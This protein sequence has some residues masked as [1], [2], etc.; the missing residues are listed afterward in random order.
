MNKS[1]HMVTVALSNDELFFKNYTSFEAKAVIKMSVLLFLCVLTNCFNGILIYCYFRYPI[2]MENSRYVLFIHMV[3][4]DSFE[5][6]IGLTMHIWLEATPL[7]L[8]PV[9]YTL[10]VIAVS[11]TLNNPINLALMALERYIAICKPLHHPKFCTFYRCIAILGLAWVISAIPAITD[12]IIVFCVEPLSF[13]RTS[14]YC[15]RG[16]LFRAP[17]QEQ[18]RLITQVILFTSVT[19][20]IILTYI[21]IVSAARSASLSKKSSAKKAYN[22]VLLHGIQLML[23]MLAFLAPLTDNLIWSL[24]NQYQKDLS[25]FRYIIAYVIPRLLSPLIYGIREENFRKHLRECLP[26]WLN[27]IRPLN[28]NIIVKPRGKKDKRVRAS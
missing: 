11:S 19:L 17:F 3:F 27:N 6:T 16:S 4:N 28:L 13:F 7:M 14:M 5:L 8:V 15:V 10:L 25:F 21:Q 1:E 22:T 24:P 20:I 12:L 9:C 23:S 26:G 18:N 2:F